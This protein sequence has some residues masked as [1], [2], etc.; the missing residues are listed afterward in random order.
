MRKYWLLVLLAVM[1][2]VAGCGRAPE[3]SPTPVATAE[4]STGPSR[5]AGPTV[6]ASGELVAAQQAEM[7]F[8]IAGQ[9]EAVA[10]VVG[11][12][13]QKRDVLVT[14]E[15]STLE[16]GVAQAEAGLDAVRAQLA[17]L[18]AGPRPGELA[19]AR[20]AYRSALAQYRKLEAAP[21]EE[22]LRI[23]TANLR[24]AEAALQQAQAEYDKAA[25][26]EN[27]TEL[28]Q[29]LALQQATLDYE[30]ALANYELVT[31]GPLPED[32]E[33]AWAQVERAQAQVDLLQAG[34]GPEQIAAAEASVAQAEAA[35]ETARATLQ[36]ARLRAPFA[37]TVAAL[38]VS[39]GDIVLPG[40][41]VLTLADLRHL[42]VQTTDLSERDV[43]RVAAGQQTH[44]YIEALGEEVEGQ[45]ARIAPLATTVG[46][47]VVYTVIIDL[48]EQLEGLRC[49]MSVEVE[50]ITE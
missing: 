13:V 41:V 35:L 23:A 46:G 15:A 1:V 42:Q 32:L 47:D 38:E 50:I 12:E 44:V 39:A 26:W 5:S 6:A 49:G 4:V 3:P 8:T 2:V 25:W 18:E 45:V 19:A 27:P 48:Q 21:R 10:V 40:R 31:H 22:E 33:A 24:K 17:E 28:P 36:Q 16:A 34:T 11:D 9:V 7:G 14:L 20:A 29:A 30:T 37:G 43:D